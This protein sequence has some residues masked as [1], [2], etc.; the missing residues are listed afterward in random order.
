QS[1]A[2]AKVRDWACVDGETSHEPMRRLTRFEYSN[3]VRDVFGTEVDV[4]SILPRDEVSLGFDNQA[5][6]LTV[7]DL[8]VD[9]YLKAADQVATAVLADPEIL[10]RLGGCGEA[11]QQ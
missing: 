2:T 7:T 6:A 5:G 11:S 4:A 8:H 10:E 9:A 3:I 1:E